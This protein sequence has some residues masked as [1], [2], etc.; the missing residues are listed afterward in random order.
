MELARFQ[1]IVAQCERLAA[2]H[3]R[4]FEFGVGALVALG[5]L[6]LILACAGMLAL[7][8]LLAAVAIELPNGVLAIW[9]VIPLYTLALVARSLSFRAERVDGI[10]IPLAA[11]PKL[12]RLLQEMSRRAKG[13]RIDRLVVR[14]DFNASL[15]QYPRAGIFGWYESTLAI[16]MPLLQGLGPDEFT[17]VLAHEIAHLNGGHGRFGVWIARQ[18]TTYQ[19]I[20]RH[21]RT[22]PRQRLSA[23]VLTPLLRWYL[24]YLYALHFALRRQHEYSADRFAAD[25]ATPEVARRALVRFEVLLRWRQEVRDVELTRLARA[26]RPV[27]TRIF[28][29]LPSRVAAE[30]S[31]AKAREWLEAALR[32]PTDFSDSHPAL[33]DRLAALG[34]TDGSVPAPAADREG[35]TALEWLAPIGAEVLAKANVAWAAAATPAWHQHQKQSSEIAQRLDAFPAAPVAAEFDV[36]REWEHAI[37]IEQQQGTTAAGP[38]ARAVVAHAPEHVGARFLVAR[39]LLADGDDAGLVELER[40]VA[41]A[42]DLVRPAADVAFPF[43][44]HQ[45]RRSEAEMWRQR[46]ATREKLRLQAARERRTGYRRMHLGPHQLGAEVVEGLRN[47]VAGVQGAKEIFLARRLVRFA[48]EIPFY[49]VG[50]VPR[51]PWYR[52]TTIRRLREITEEVFRATSWPHET[53]VLPVTG[54]LRGL[55]RKMRRLEEAQ[56]FPRR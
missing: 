27:P 49:V 22:A 16:G 32:V 19:N 45:G 38:L 55:R 21:L 37:L 25:F 5:Y 56:L 31:P 24:P 8:A 50:V 35:R 54:E 12:A 6:Y 46:Q 52:A 9:A 43:L 44:W 1:R 28:D 4:K 34:A 51:L 47:G 20:E 40:L 17:A 36:A 10:E 3:P 33:R 23:W 42:P 14:V 13:P 15:S 48:P 2:R 41:R 26:G 39:A 53:I 7:F 30:V 11:V 18:F 29:D